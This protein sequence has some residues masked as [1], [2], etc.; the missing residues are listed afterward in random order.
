MACVAVSESDCEAMASAA[1]LQFG[2]SGTGFNTKGCYAYNASHP[3]YGGKVYYGSGASESDQMLP[4]FAPR[5]RPQCE[6]NSSLTPTISV[7]LAPVARQYLAD[8]PSDQTIGI[9]RYH[10]GTQ[11]SGVF[12]KPIPNSPTAGTAQA[13]NDRHL[14]LKAAMPVTFSVPVAGEYMLGIHMRKGCEQFRL[15]GSTF[16]PNES[17]KCLYPCDQCQRMNL[18]CIHTNTFFVCSSDPRDTPTN[19]A[20]SFDLQSCDKHHHLGSRNG[21]PRGRVYTFPADQNITLYL[22]ARETCT[23][24]GEIKLYN[25][26]AFPTVVYP[27]TSLGDFVFDLWSPPKPCTRF[28]ASDLAATSACA[29]GIPLALSVWLCMRSRRQRQLVATAGPSTQESRAHAEQTISSTLTSNHMR[30]I[31]VRQAAFGLRLRV[32]G[33]AFTLGWIMTCYGLAPTIR[34]IQ[35]LSY[36]ENNAL[37]PFPFWLVLFAPGAMLMMLAVLPIDRLAIHTLYVLIFCVNIALAVIG[38]AGA[39]IYHGKYTRLSSGSSGWGTSVWATW[40]AQPEAGAMIAL[41]LILCMAL[42]NMRYLLSRRAT[43]RAALLRLWASVRF[44]CA[45]AGTVLILLVLVPFTYR[46]MSVFRQQDIFCGV[47]GLWAISQGLA[48][49]TFVALAALASPTNRGRVH[50]WLA[51]L[52]DGGPRLQRAAV[53]ASLLGDSGSSEDALDRAKARFFTIAFDKLEANC[54]DYEGIGGGLEHLK[55]RRDQRKKSAHKDEEENGGSE[56][57]ETSVAE[58]TPPAH[59]LSVLGQCDAF[60]SHAWIDEVM[61][62]GDKYSALQRWA[63]GQPKMPRLWIDRISLRVVDIAQTLPLLPI[64]II[65]SNNFMI[66]AGPAYSSRLWTILELF[67]FVQCNEGNMQRAILLPVGGAR[68]DTLLATFDARQAQCTLPDDRNTLLGI[69]ESSFGDL[70]AF[71]KAVRRLSISGNSSADSD[72]QS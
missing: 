47:S 64:F 13:G 17:P 53:I 5:Y 11:A 40:N 12:F 37:G 68:A 8:H 9:V 15:R 72:L 32:S 18:G 10:N 57:V 3:T 42:A 39:A 63:N 46:P 45:Y 65:G 7:E 58:T 21:E 70:C 31:P 14:G 51:K 20:T 25:A 35:I 59:E 29:F 33:A 23:V 62:P 61:C 67:T 54:F 27:R 30:L 22:A 36:F 19:P 16:D 28:Y 38:A 34:G 44:T 49:G 1:G 41:I 43:G 55:Q 4:V 50:Q 24:A 26:Q 6:G 69:I 52:A 56:R 60:V 48:G 71:N 2:G 66:L